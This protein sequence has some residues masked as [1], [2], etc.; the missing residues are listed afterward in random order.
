MNENKVKYAFLNQI[1]DSVLNYFDLTLKENS[2]TFD[3][4]GL[5]NGLEIIEIISKLKIKRF[6]VVKYSQLIRLINLMDEA[7]HLDGYTIL[8][9]VQHLS[10]SQSYGMIKMDLGIENTDLIN[11]RLKKSVNSEIIESIK[12]NLNKKSIEDILKDMNENVINES[13]FDGFNS[14]A[15]T[16]N[17][18]NEDIEYFYMDLFIR[19]NF[20]TI[21]SQALAQ[22][23][24][25]LHASLKSDDILETTIYQ[26]RDILEIISRFTQALLASNEHFLDKAVFQM[27]VDLFKNKDLMSFLVEAH[28]KIVCKIICIFLCLCNAIFYTNKPINQILD[29]PKTFKVLKE[30]RDFLEEITDD[31]NYPDRTVTYRPIYR[32]FLASLTYLQKKLNSSQNLLTLEHYEFFASGGHTRTKFKSITKYF[33]EEGKSIVARFE[34]INEF[35]RKEASKVT[36]TIIPSDKLTGINVLAIYTVVRT[37]ND[38]RRIFSLT[39]QTRIIGFEN[40]KYYIFSIIFYGLDIEKIL[41][42]KYLIEYSQVGQIKNEILNETCLFEYLNDLKN[43]YDDNYS[44][45][46][47]E[48]RLNT[49]IGEFLA[50]FE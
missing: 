20:F 27:I 19:Y 46:Q 47:M 29:E 17:K 24:G 32:A 4:I 25:I 43:S 14:I 13:I 5:Q 1:I 7:T 15:A 8:L 38:Q 22:T 23:L 49:I 31:R 21:I 2:A 12:S 10:Q 39:D 44:C 42:L 30:T 37:I 50:L 16:L 11:Q 33:R 40:Y 3:L 26:L 45:N 41:S 9:I 48:I 28:I 35:G 6:L 34:Y 18:D 36:H